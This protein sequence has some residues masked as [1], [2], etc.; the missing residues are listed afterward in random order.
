MKDLENVKLMCDM[1]HKCPV[2]KKLIDVAMPE[3]NRQKTFY[4]FCSERCKLIDLGHWLDGNYRIISDS[5]NK[6]PEEN[7]DAEN[8]GQYKKKD[9]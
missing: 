7:N 3:Q 4:P 6:E 9:R 2:C 8:S 5:K 1:K